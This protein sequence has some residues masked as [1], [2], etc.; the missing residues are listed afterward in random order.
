MEIFLVGRHALLPLPSPL[1]KGEEGKAKR[2]GG[3]GRVGEEGGA[4]GDPM[5]T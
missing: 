4:A 2:E 3:I 1:A 5:N